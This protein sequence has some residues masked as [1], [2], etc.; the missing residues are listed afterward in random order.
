[1]K[2]ILLALFAFGLGIVTGWFVEGAAR[3]LARFGD[4]WLEGAG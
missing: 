4:D 1:M 3:A 2:G